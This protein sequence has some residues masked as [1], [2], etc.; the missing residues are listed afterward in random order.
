LD[1]ISADDLAA[2]LG[3]WTSGTGPLHRK[4][5]SALTR[6]VAGGDLPPGATLPAERA[7]ARTLGVARGTVVAAL[8]SLATDGLVARRQGSGTLVAEGAARAGGGP[9]PAER[10]RP[11]VPG[12]LTTLRGLVGAVEGAIELSA[13]APTGR[14]VVDDEVWAAARADAEELAAGHGYLPGGLPALRE[15]VAA[16]VSGWGLPTTARQVVVTAG[17]QQALTLLAQA[18][19][20]PG[21]A[22]ALEDP[23]YP[24][25]I[26]A[27]RAAGARLVGV[28]L[29][30]GGMR[31][32][33]LRDAVARERPRLVYV[34]PTAQN[35]S[36][37]VMPP[38][39]R[40]LLLEVAAA[41]GA[42]V[43]DDCTL[44]DLAVDPAP[45]PLAALASGARVVTVGS[46]S[47]LFWGGLRLGWVRADPELVDALTERKLVADHGSPLV[48]QALG[49]RLLAWRAAPAAAR[50]RAEM[51]ERLAAVAPLLDAQLP[52]WTWARPAGGLCL[53]LRMP[54]GDAREL[55]AVALR[56]GVAV[57]P[58]P[59]ASPE[60][61][62]A[63]RVRIALVHDTPMLAEGVRRL[64]R[65]WAAYAPDAR[66]GP[67]R[68]A[69]VV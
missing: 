29:D 52:G 33:A 19:L 47:K 62:F 14:G 45:P 69:V 27:L 1:Q 2:R 49:A 63:D 41:H 26:D 44:H 65:A 20:A 57:V 10:P 58:G 31:V 48:A 39:R 64:G 68:L 35:P 6:A 61:G 3:D 25:A 34:V 9:V 21:D 55:A 18:L 17:A 12:G 38:A 16:H 13:A 23:T 51:A 60:G 37:T 42:T 7:I 50:R 53:W 22:V 8:A 4:L 32:D 36:G 5:A 15:A 56:A 28:P 43:V 54:A 67:D 59:V 40:R 11:A 24:G 46:L 30:G 66:A